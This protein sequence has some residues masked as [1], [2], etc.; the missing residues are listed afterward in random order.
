MAWS[1]THL[2]QTHTFTAAQYLGNYGKEAN[3]LWHST[4]T[5]RNPWLKIWR[6]NQCTYSV[7]PFPD[8]AGKWLNLN[9]C[10]DWKATGQHRSMQPCCILGGGAE[11]E[12]WRQPPW[13]STAVTPLRHMAEGRE[14]RRW[15]VQPR[16]CYHPG[17][18][19]HHYTSG[20]SI[21]VLL[22]C[23]QKICPRLLQEF[24]DTCTIFLPERFH[25]HVSRSRT[26]AKASAAVEGLYLGC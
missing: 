15:L 6:Q 1:K 10:T 8:S 20:L 23:L 12:G 19:L 2:Q 4:V 21:P 18:S 9:P 24:S 26:S 25:R 13:A 17:I 3:L 11:R 14:T 16:K 5:Q 22:H 7:Q